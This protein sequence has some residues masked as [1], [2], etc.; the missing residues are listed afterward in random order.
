MQK[1][2][3]LPPRGGILMGLQSG[4]P[5]KWLCVPHRRIMAKAAVQRQAS[6]GGGRLE[7]RPPWG[8]FAKPHLPVT[9]LLVA[10]C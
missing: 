5:A 9:S 10:Q 3:G 1:P 2:D 4:L 7:I 8:R 6:A